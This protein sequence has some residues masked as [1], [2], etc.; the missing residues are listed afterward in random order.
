MRIIALV[1]GLIAFA[2]PCHAAQQQDDASLAKKCRQMVGRE[3]T[4]GTGQDSHVGHFQAQR[5]S[6]CMMGR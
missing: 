5:F 6:D 1:F 3:A 2:G 4:E